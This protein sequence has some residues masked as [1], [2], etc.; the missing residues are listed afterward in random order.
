M[1][2][3]A[4]DDAARRAWLEGEIAW[5]RKHLES[6]ERDQRRAPWLLCGILLSIPAAFVWGWFRA[7]LVVLAA[8]ALTLGALYLTGVHRSQYRQ[9]IA[10][11][12]RELKDRGN[13][14][15]R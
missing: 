2:E 5:N 11:L 13:L 4:P 3:P 15:A 1:S 8:I 14:R 12:E 7:A 6:V 9:K 10:E